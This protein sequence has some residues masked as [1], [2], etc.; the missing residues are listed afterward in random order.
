MEL[1]PL[2]FGAPLTLVALAALPV[3]YWLLRVT[4]PAPRRI[5]FPPL[6][7]LL[8]LLP[9]K[10]RARAVDKARMS[11]AAVK[12]FLSIKY[13]FIFIVVNAQAFWIGPGPG[14]FPLYPRAG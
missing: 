8:D 1:L 6:R 14:I 13:P 2:T 4:P 12:S 9:E 3:L 5:D 11:P 7:I 10:E